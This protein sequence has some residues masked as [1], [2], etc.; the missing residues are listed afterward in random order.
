MWWVSLLGVILVC[1]FTGSLGPP[2]Q[3]Q[4][5]S[6]W[7][8]RENILQDNHFY[9]ILNGICFQFSVKN[10][11]DLR[12]F[13]L[14]G[15]RKIFLRIRKFFLKEFWL[16]KYFLVL[17]KFFLI[18]LRKIF[19]VI[20]KFFLIFLSHSQENIFLKSFLKTRKYFLETRKYFLVLRKIFLLK[21][22]FSYEAEQLKKFFLKI[23]K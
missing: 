13:F 4:L 23:R 7:L 14:I 5:V 19:L 17:R 9:I 20:R 6:F 10:F 21:K 3:D 18:G 16:R 12:K 15:L 8:Y 1:V 2:H 22:K 11:L